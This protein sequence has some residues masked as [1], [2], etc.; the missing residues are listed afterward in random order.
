MTSRTSR[1]KLVSLLVLVNYAYAAPASTL[2]ATSPVSVVLGGKTYVNK[3][4]VGFGLIASDFRESTG[5][6]LGG[7]GSAIDIKS[8][9][10]KM[11]NGTYTGTFVVQPDRG[12]NI[13]GTID[14]QSR[15][16]EI[17]F[18]FT[19]Y[20]GSANLKFADAQQTLKLQYK[21]T[22][23]TFERNHTKTSGLDP[24]AIRAAQSGGPA[25][26]FPDP[27]MPIVSTALPHLTID[28]EGLVSNAD[29][30]FW[31]SDEY[32][33]YIYRFSADGQLIQ[34]IQPPN[35]FLPRD[36]SG[37]LQFTSETSPATGRSDNQGFEGLTVDHSNQVLY[38]MLQS[39][40]IQD[41]GDKKST[42]RFTRMIAY[43]ISNP[44]VQPTLVGEWVIPLP[45]S[46]KG[47]TQASSEL[48][49]VS[50]GVFLTLARDGDGR[51]GDDNNTKYKQADLFSIAGATDIH[52]TKFDNPANPIAT[53]GKLVSTITPA[54]YVSFVNFVETM[55][56]ARFG[57]HNGSPND[58]TLIDAKW[59]SLTLAPVGDPAFPDDFFL[60]TAS[61]ND[62]I[63][64]NGV[65]LGVPFDA[66]LD[67]DN[68]FLVF[69][70]TLP[71]ALN[72]L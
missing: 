31:I 61:D 48:H 8:G 11:V 14:Y 27:Q 13:D 12:F 58:E 29:G 2:A 26:T 68:Q 45:L 41:G 3:G 55:G 51:G 5:D 25:V 37:V 15:I 34:T 42:S 69:R 18:T 17:D 57:L 24:T 35:A 19:P 71:G 21:S 36:S 64:T 47:N 53:D 66:G 44:S 54:T 4:L 62:F 22:M 30:S 50:P 59:E 67:V 56:L 6:T 1:A 40:T 52:G 43:D 20:Y 10:W 33:P 32:G 28:A 65:S 63:S 60:F 39:A 7:I 16:H 72:T 70:L 46:S 9:T 23:L 49:F 38:A